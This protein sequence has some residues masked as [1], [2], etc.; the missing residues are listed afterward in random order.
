MEGQRPAEEHRKRKTPWPLIL[1]GVLGVYVVLIALLNSDEVKVDFVFFSAQ[2]RLLFLI[3]LC[4]GV[5]FGAGWVFEKM[6]ARR[7]R[8]A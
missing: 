4:L 7:K 8:A 1:F 3:L 6:R 5:G 2:I